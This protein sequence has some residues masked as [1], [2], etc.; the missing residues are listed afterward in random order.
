MQ[1]RYWEV[2]LR[3]NREMFLIW[4]PCQWTVVTHFRAPVALGGVSLIRRSYALGPL[5]GNTP[6]D[7]H[8]QQT[9]FGRNWPAEM[10]DSFS[11]ILY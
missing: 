10:R 2:V 7:P 3:R 6:G 9:L 8:H 4:E 5:P 1:L 11:Y